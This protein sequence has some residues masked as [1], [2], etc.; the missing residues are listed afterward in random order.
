M[1]TGSPANSITCFC[2]DKLPLWLINTA[3]CR[4]DFQEIETVRSHSTAAGTRGFKSS[5]PGLK[6]KDCVDVDMF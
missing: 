4:T 2:I 3:C 1:P 6:T 5:I